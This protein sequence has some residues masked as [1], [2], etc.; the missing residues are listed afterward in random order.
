MDYER[1]SSIHWRK[2]KCPAT[3]ANDLCHVVPK[4][5]TISNKLSRRLLQP[6][7]RRRRTQVSTK[8]WNM[9]KHILH[10]MM[11]MCPLKWLESWEENRPET[12][13]ND[14]WSGSIVICMCRVCFLILVCCYYCHYFARNE[15]KWMK[16]SDCLFSFNNILIEFPFNACKMCVLRR[17]SSNCF[18]L[19]CVCFICVSG[20]RLWHATMSFGC[21]AYCHQAGAT[22]GSTKCYSLP[23]R[24]VTCTVFVEWQRSRLRHTRLQ[25]DQK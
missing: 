6:V 3:M 24:V 4:W 5:I 14:L 25:L 17:K 21:R 19:L 23:W 20:F 10:F 7:T 9:F 12:F 18:T 2:L 15:F 11:K 13:P 22:F 16:T 1:H 8:L